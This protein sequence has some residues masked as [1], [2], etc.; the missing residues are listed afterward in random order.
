MTKK[1]K[2]KSFPFRGFDLAHYKTT[3]AYARLIDALSDKGTWESNP[4]VFAYD[5]DLVK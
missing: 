1:Q 2:K 3:A 5:F 4:Y